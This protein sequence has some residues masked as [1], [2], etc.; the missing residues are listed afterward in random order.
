MLQHITTQ[1]HV[2]ASLFL[3]EE[4]QHAVLRPQIRT[5]FS[6][7]ILNRHWPPAARIVKEL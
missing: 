1:A 7:N 2:P 5:P 6:P 3:E 4:R